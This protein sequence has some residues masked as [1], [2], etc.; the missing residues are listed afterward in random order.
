MLNELR[1]KSLAPKQCPKCQAE[2]SF[3]ILADQLICR[4]C[5]Y[6]MPRIDQAAK[7]NKPTESPFIEN[8]SAAI[9][10]EDNAAYGP[11]RPI[12]PPGFGIQH[13]GEVNKWAK[14]AYESAITYMR[15]EKWEDAAK[16][17]QR[18]L[19]VQPDLADAHYYLALITRDP[20]KKREHL[21]TVIAH[22]P[23]HSAAIR[24][25]MILNGDLSEADEA[26][27]DNPFHEPEIIEASGAVGVTTTNL[28]CPKC[29]APHMTTDDL[30]GLIF[31]K[32]CGHVDEKRQQ[33]GSGGNL[34]MALLERR[35][36]P[37]KWIIGERLL[38]C[39]SCGAERTVS[40][41]KLSTGCI[42]CGS[43]H[44]FEKDALDS[45]EQPQGLVPFAI[46]QE[47]A[48]QAIR[49]RLKG[50]FERFKGWFDNNRIERVNLEGHY[51]PFWVFDVQVS[52]RRTIIRE[53]SSRHQS[54]ARLSPGGLP[55]DLYHTETLMDSMFNVLVSAVKSPSRRMTDKLGE[56]D[57]SAM[58]GYESK[59]LAKHPAQ[60]YSVDVD[61]ASLTARS[62]VGEAMRM[63][64]S[65]HAAQDATV[66]I[67]T[68]PTGMSYQLVLLPV[69]VATLY[70]LDGD[71]RNALVN[72]Q[73]GKVIL[74][75]THK[76]G[77]GY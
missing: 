66:N 73:T 17:F 19:D 40:G 20:E 22:Q 1:L 50:W 77:I 56:F 69:W 24:E 61:V 23:A 58:I 74:G 37:V 34:V 32:S 67:T 2:R 53:P 47:Q 4:R 71:V 39:E 8:V 30:T 18:A 27:L 6:S 42:Y 41:Q 57:L 3:K 35:A 76:P 26:V 13:V 15:Q 68:T 59:L 44:I 51:L 48:E 33:A 43:N 9:A 70:E 5:G 36:Q 62:I 38:A 52:V 31:C 25:L 11:R 75:K 10:P 16:A 21:S 65:L 7:R 28:R 12:P 49:K 64:H 14:A 54:Y 72:G 60:I 63:R 45:F 29:G 55:N 46:N